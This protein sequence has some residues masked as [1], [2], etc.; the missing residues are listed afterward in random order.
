MSQLSYKAAQLHIESVAL[1][2]LAERFGT[3]LYIYSKSQIIAN[4]E[5]FRAFWPSQHK[6]CYAVK[7]NSSLAILQLLVKQGAWFDIVS[8]GELKRVLA[9]GGKAEHVVFSGVAKSEAEIRFALEQGIGCFNV[10]SAA[11]LERIE[12]VAQALKT[13]APVSLRVNPDV[14]AKTHPYI[15]TGLKA[16]KF[17]IPMDDAMAVFRRAHT[18]NHIE[19]L[20][21]DCHIGSQIMTDAPFLDAAKRMFRLLERLRDEAIE[22]SHLDLGGG[23]GIDYQ[24]KQTLDVQS[25]LESVIELAKDYPQLTLML[26]PGRAIVAD[27]GVLLSQVEYTKQSDDKQFVLVDAGMNDLMRPSLYQAWHDILPV[28]ESNSVA[29]AIVDVVGPVCETGCFLGHARHLNVQAG[30]FIAVNHAGAYGFTMASNYNTRMRP[31]EVLV[32]D[33]QVWLIRERETFDDLIRGER[34]IA[35]E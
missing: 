23:F 22:L 33:D 5:K 24:G 25:Y 28:N 7:A 19:L 30:D 11:E 29:D 26:E 18:L 21:A 10:E 4:W 3:P 14:D 32:E 15:S 16:N 8:G 9:A 2:T 34:L 31:A 12:Q 13:R 6:L 27:A 20:G 1:P 17:G 35:E